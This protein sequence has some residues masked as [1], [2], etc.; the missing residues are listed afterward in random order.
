MA[1]LWALDPANALVAGGLVTQVPVTATVDLVNDGIA[2][3]TVVVDGALTVLRLNSV[4]A[5]Q[6]VAGA[7]VP[8]RP[9]I[10]FMTFVF[11][12]PGLAYLS[13]SLV[14][15]TDGEWTVEISG[16]AGVGNEVSVWLGGVLATGVVPND[17]QWHVVVVAWDEAT[18][19]TLYLDGAVIGETAAVLA[20]SV[21]TTLRLG[22]ATYSSDNLA[23]TGTRLA[24]A[25]MESG[26]LADPMTQATDLLAEFGDISL[27]TGGVLNWLLQED[28]G[29]PITKCVVDLAVTVDGL[30]EFVSVDIFPDPE[31]GVIPDSFDVFAF[32]GHPAYGVAQVT[33]HNAMGS[34]APVAAV[35]F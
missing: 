7:A 15:G 18:G 26:V 2:G 29:S 24:V 8:A 6:L 9:S 31:T 35:M 12:V 28:G 30:P 10:G 27:L 11:G 4:A 32:L 21:D 22:A 13:T 1:V 20:V 14:I 34:S 16:E 33:V 23:T 19:I 5:D 17:G 25:R 3:A